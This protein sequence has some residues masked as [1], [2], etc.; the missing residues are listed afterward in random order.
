MVGLM[1]PSGSPIPTIAQ[2]TTRN[3]PTSSTRGLP[4]AGGDGQ[5]GDRR[6]QHHRPDGLNDP[7]ASSPPSTKRVAPS[8]AT[9]AAPPSW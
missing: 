6:P 2:V 1:I 4:A 7:G 3:P 5:A 8:I 9:W